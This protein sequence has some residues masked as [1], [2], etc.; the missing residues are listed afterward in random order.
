M[1]G[2]VF[3][4]SM[5]TTLFSNRPVKSRGVVAGVPRRAAVGAAGKAKAAARGRAPVSITSLMIVV[6]FFDIAFPRKSRIG[7]PTTPVYQPKNNGSMLTMLQQTDND[8]FCSACGGNGAL[9]CCDGCV[10]SYHF[11]CVDPPVD[12]GNL[13]EKWFCQSCATRTQ[14]S[15]PSPRGLFGQLASGLDETSPVAY[16]LPGSHRDLFEGVGTGPG[17]EF[18]DAPVARLK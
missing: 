2:I 14:P 5:L 6:C 12:A 11:N 15:Q 8:D 9:I 13:P 18:V 16:A 7:P 3:K 10:R 4:P 17:G 1:R